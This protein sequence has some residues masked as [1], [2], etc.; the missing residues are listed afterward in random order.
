MS[1]QQLGVNSHLLLGPTPVNKTSF[2]GYA[3]GADAIT[4]GF[5][6]SAAATAGGRGI[7]GSQPAPWETYDFGLGCRSNPRHDPILRAAWAA[8]LY[9][10]WAGRGGQTGKPSSEFEAVT[11]PALTFGYE[12]DIVSWALALAVD[13]KPA[14]A[15]L[16]AALDRPTE[17]ERSYLMSQCEF[18]FGTNATLLARL[19]NSL[20]GDFALGCNATITRDKVRSSTGSN[21]ITADG[22]KVELTASTTVVLD[23]ETDKLASMVAG[24]L[25][26]HRVDADW[27]YAIPAWISARPVTS[28]GEGV[29]TMAV[30]FNQLTAGS[31]INSQPTPGGDALDVPADGGE[32]YIVDPNGG[33]LTRVTAD[34]PVPAGGFGFAG[35]PIAGE[36]VQN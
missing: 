33:I 13:G 27:G 26:I 6:Q 34:T 19:T 22:I 28:P 17:A 16:P 11:T 2:T 35:L 12:T 21:G 4:A 7:G 18:W 10:T 5:S 1:T 25:V 14:R 29:I 20:R 30:T 8:R 23:A 36:A 9:G 31:P 32:G 15:P 3:S 24:I